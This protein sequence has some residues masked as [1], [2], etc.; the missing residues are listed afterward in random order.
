MS[1]N[2]T[3]ADLEQL[4][5]LSTAYSTAGAEIAGQASDLR[6]RIQVAVDGFAATMSRLHQQSTT[7]TQGMNDET[8]SVAATASGVAWTGSNRAAFDGDMQTFV[9]SVRT[10]TASIDAGVTELRRSVDQR[11]N[12]VLEE[13]SV[14]VTD[15]ADGV[16]LTTGDVRR[17]VI[18]QRQ[19]LEEA[20]NVGWT[21]A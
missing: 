13:F 2:M 20:A 4:D 7:L 11:F 10:G 15:A 21:S 18:G 14:S 3:G 16:E 6:Q 12:P 5:A 1:E 8:A 9:S 17:S 19:Q